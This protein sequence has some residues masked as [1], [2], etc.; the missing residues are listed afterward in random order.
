MYIPF[1]FTL[2]LQSEIQFY[3]TYLWVF[4]LT[5]YIENVEQSIGYR[6]CK[7]KVIINIFIVIP[8]HFY[9]KNPP[10]SGKYTRKHEDERLQ[11]EK[12]EEPL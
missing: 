1:V 2:L 7:R 10:F 8:K 6:H 11:T 3:I 5:L 4:L 12:K 9:D